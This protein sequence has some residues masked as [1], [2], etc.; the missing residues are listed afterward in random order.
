MSSWLQKQRKAELVALADEAGFTGYESMLKDDLV[1]SLDEHLKN[2]A[3]RLAGN[4]SFA[5]YYERSSSPVKRTRANAPAESDGEPREPRSTRPRRRVTRIKQEQIDSQDEVEATPVQTKAI[6]TRTPRSVQRVA[7]QVPLPPSPAVVTDA[8]ERQTAIVKES[9]GNAWTNSGVTD[10][11][12][13]IREVLSSVVGV[14]AAVVLVEAFYLQKQVMPWFYFF[15]IPAIN[16]LGTNSYPVQFPELFVLLTSSFWSPSLLWAN[17]SLFIPLFFAYFF[18]LTLKST[19][20]GVTSKKP[21]YQ[22]DPLTF[23]IAKALVSYMVYGQGVRFSGLVAD[24]TVLT[25]A[26][27]LPGGHH[28]VLIGAGIGALASIYE[29]VLKR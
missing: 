11:A 12:E 7:A 13:Y 16:A 14:E 3:T 27:A 20:P 15:D 9:V 19:V 29:A 6:A 28:G 5:E 26:D 25:V 2:N 18:N 4:S 23:N 10:Y 21:A 24:E 17:T 22:V 8:I 1:A